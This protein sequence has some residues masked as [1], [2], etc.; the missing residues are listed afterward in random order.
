MT[1]QIPPVKPRTQTPPT[2]PELSTSVSSRSELVLNTERNLETAIIQL[3][4]PILSDLNILFGLSGVMHEY[5]GLS[6]PN[7]ATSVLLC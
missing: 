7:P 5:F 2:G 6:M 1:K 3:S 4:N